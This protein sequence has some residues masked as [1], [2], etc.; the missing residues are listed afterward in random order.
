MVSRRTAARQ[1]LLRPGRFFEE[2]EPSETLPWATGAVCLSLVTSLVAV[3]LVGQFIAGA[4]EGPI[5]VD[6]PA[7]PGDAFCDMPPEQP[8]QIE[9]GCAEPRQVERSP[10][11]LVN[12]AIAPFYVFV[13][14]G[15]LL[16]WGLGT[17]LFYGLARIAGGSPSGSGTAVVAGWLAVPETLRAIVG[18]V[19]IRHALADVTITDIEAETDVV[20]D[21]LHSVSSVLL[22]VSVLVILWQWYIATNGMA[23]EADIS[24]GEAAAVTG[25]PLLLVVPLGLP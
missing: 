24:K 22:V 23:A 4:V 9:T 19:A 6:N 16:L 17:G 13:F 21:A 5:M 10:E 8:G 14:I 3:Y 12:E 2:R 1:F 7:Y 18:V 25:L 20:L 15:V 11:S